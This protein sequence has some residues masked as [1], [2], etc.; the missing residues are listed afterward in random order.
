MANRRR[1]S[2]L[3]GRALRKKKA[4][5]L[6]F[7]DVLLIMLDLK[8]LNFVKCKSESLILFNGQQFGH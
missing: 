6:F 8:Q 4:M 3:A 5:P 2:L 1:F 7:S